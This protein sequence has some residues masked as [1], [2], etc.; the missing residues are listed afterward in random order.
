M[1]SLFERTLFVTRY[2][3]VPAHTGALRYS[4]QLIRTL[5][6]LSARVDVLCQIDPRSGPIPDEA[7]SEFSDN[8]SFFM[9]PPRTPSLAERVLSSLPHAAITHATAENREQLDEL[10]KCHPNCIVVDH[11]AS[12]WAYEQLKSYKARHAHVPIVY[13]THN[14]ERDTRLSLFYESRSRPMLLLGSLIDVLR[15]DRS[16]RRL[17]R[18]SD[19]VTCISSVDRAKYVARYRPAQ[20]VVVRP[21]YWG[22]VR[23]TRKIDTSVPRRVCLVGSFV[24]SPKRSNLSAFLREGYRAFVSRGIEVLVVG[25]MDAAHRKVVQGR[26][27]A[28]TFTGSVARVESYL[29]SSRVGVIP[30]VAGGGFKLKSLEYVFNRVPI[31]ALTNAVVDLPLVAEES[32]EL[33]SDIPSLCRGIVDNIDN[34]RHLNDMQ[35]KAFEACAAFRSEQEPQKVLDEAVIRSRSNEPAADLGSARRVACSREFGS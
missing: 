9:Q 31:F 13:C 20:A 5:A 22:H 6:R 19:L 11:I 2:Y 34:L 15:I 14:V 30:E 10:L 26:W 25:R 8:V 18:L 33:F 1:S 16:D 23:V 4:S 24:S 12:A 3:P 29:A 7:F 28:A 21:T 27:P 35:Q 17:A 32:I